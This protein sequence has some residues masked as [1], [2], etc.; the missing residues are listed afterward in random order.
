MKRKGNEMI[1]ITRKDLGLF[2]ATVNG[3]ES[4]YYIRIDSNLGSGRGSQFYSIFKKGDSTYKRYNSHLVKLNI[5][6]AKKALIKLLS[7]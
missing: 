1:E 2:T 6:K 3:V 4:D 5:H 7:N